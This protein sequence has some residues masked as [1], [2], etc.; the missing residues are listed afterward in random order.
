MDR[1]A[2]K[3]ALITGGARGQ[4]ASEA[5]LFAEEG[6]AVVITDILP[7]G[8]AMAD[9]IGGTFFEHDV[10]DVA[11]WKS[12]TDAVVAK[13]G[14]IDILINNAGIFRLGGVNDTDQELWD[15][16]IAINQ[17]GVFLG[18]QAVAPT[19]VANSSGSIINIS[20]IA[21]LR[22]AS[23]ALAYGASKWAVR[24][25]TKSVARE[26]APNGVRVN[27]IHPGIIDT[28]MLQTFDN[29]GLREQVQAA[30]PMGFE[31]S[32]DDVA[33]MALFLA[34]DESRYCTG[35]EFIVD[36]GMTC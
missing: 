32:A 26:L 9:K 13:H 10:T 8:Q 24:G 14:K 4:G 36:G 11:A 35:S 33:N 27:S 1:L 2:G 20:S 17:T 25:M 3:V 31:A 22:G 6:A 16:T 30:I 21:G 29:A 34:S 12:I 19:M 23:V 28:P 15:T 7:E 5:A 18:M